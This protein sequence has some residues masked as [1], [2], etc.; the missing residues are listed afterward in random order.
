MA[1]TAKRR[2][3]SA[4]AILSAGPQI[5]EHHFLQRVYPQE[6]AN[7]G[8]KEHYLISAYSDATDEYGEDWSYHPNAELWQFLTNKRY[9]MMQETLLQGHPIQ[10]KTGGRSLEPLVYSGDICFIW[11]LQPGITQIKPGDIVFCQVQPRQ[12][13]YVHLVWSVSN[14]RTKTGTERTCYLI[15]NNKQGEGKKYN[16]YCY[17]EHIY[18]IVRMTSKGVYSHLIAQ[19]DPG[20]NVVPN[21]D[22]EI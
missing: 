16:G 7:Y 11:P 22:E 15:G 3:K 6:F 18:G 13:Y 4:T 5:P 12:T 8:T 19:N 9:E 14:Y 10:F 17:R 21:Y 1:G 20:S 2:T